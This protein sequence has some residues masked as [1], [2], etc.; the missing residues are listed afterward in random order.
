MELDREGYFR[1]CDASVM[2]RG[3]D[4]VSGMMRQECRISTGGSGGQFPCQPL[5]EGGVVLEVV[6]PGAEA[7]RLAGGD[8]GGEVVDVERF[9]GDEGVLANGEVVDGPL[10]L[11][12]AGEVG[13]DG[14]MEVGEARILLEDP[15][16]M[17]G[18]GV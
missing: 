14:A 18:V 8:V 3:R 5:L 11:D 4:G 13:E 16:A 7:E 10:G 9:G 2:D 6:L 15:R 17:D 1:S 12:A